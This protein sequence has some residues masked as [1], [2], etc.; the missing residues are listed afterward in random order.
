MRVRAFPSDSTGSGHYRIQ[1]PCAA[2][3]AAGCDVSIADIAPAQP[4]VQAKRP[5]PI[6]R[7]PANP[8]LVR[9]VP[10]DADIV[11]FQRPVEEAAARVAI[12]QLQASGVAVVV[13]I[14]DDLE[15]LDA[16]H[17][18][19]RALNPTR[20]PEAN[21]RFL[22]EACRQAD[23]VTVSSHA[24]AARYAPHGRVAVLP[25]CV[26]ERL[27]GMPRASDGRT[28]GWRG[29]TVTHPGDLDVTRGGVQTALEQTGGRF[30]HIGSPEGVRA[31][32]GLRE[33]PET[34]GPLWNIDD[35]YS[36]LGRIDVGIVPLA[37][38]QFNDAKSCLAGVEYAARG[39]AFV[40]SPVAEHRR[41]AAQGAGVLA[42]YRAREWRREIATL[43]SD[44]R[45]R[46]EHVQAARAVVTERYVIER[47]AH[48]WCEAWQ[49]ALANAHSRLRTPTAA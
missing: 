22:R 12:P 25:N 15:R 13:E 18:A 21:W 27:L 34:T 40:A 24:L 32:L 41:L 19:H 4:G 14:D 49:Q 30:L 8:K 10:V 47:R 29:W 5:L 26:P 48:L 3:K 42:G 6:Q 46:A 2:A 20:S 35:F 39:V 37:S 9:A 28:V 1:L 7:H 45:L 33:P 16:R 36:A 17:P 43:L 44:D 31:G 23:L 11:V 38:T